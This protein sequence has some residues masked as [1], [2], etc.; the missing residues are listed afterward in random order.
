MS[1]KFKSK[2]SI[3]IKNSYSGVFVF[4]C[5][6]FGQF[7][8]WEDVCVVQRSSTGQSDRLRAEPGQWWRTESSSQ[9]L[10]GGST[11]TQGYSNS[12][13]FSNIV[14]FTSILNTQICS[15][16]MIYMRTDTLIVWITLR[17]FPFYLYLVSDSVSWIFHR[18]KTISFFL[19]CH[20]PQ[21]SDIN[22]QEKHVSFYVLCKD[23]S[24]TKQ[25]CIINDFMVS[26]KRHFYTFT[27]DFQVN[28]GTRVRIVVDS[29]LQLN[30]A[31]IE[32]S[33]CAVRSA[34]DVLKNKIFI[35]VM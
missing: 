21:R 20:K 3:W 34:R 7:G 18:R 29:L 30:S 22:K 17:S 6:S 33:E 15:S 5:C 28:I 27:S 2:G 10:S 1:S 35:Q 12:S 13:V 8:L 4:V 31:D 24:V 25:T 19:L 16:F 11:T 32:G 9:I 14:V 23:K 26:E